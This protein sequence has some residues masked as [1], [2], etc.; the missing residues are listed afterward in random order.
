MPI[1]NKALPA[2]VRKTVSVP[3]NMLMGGSLGFRG[4][5]YN[6]NSTLHVGKGTLAVNGNV[7]TA[8]EQYKAD[9]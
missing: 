2:D 8:T 9:L 4:D 1:L 6:T 5:E 3:K 7:N